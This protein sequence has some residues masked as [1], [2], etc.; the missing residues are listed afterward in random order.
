MT[1]DPV[2]RIR[3][4]LAR[5][6]PPL[7]ELL[8]RNRFDPE[9][10]LQRVA[11]WRDG[12][13]SEA[14][15]RVTGRVEPPGP[16]HIDVL[17]EPGSAAHAAAH[18]A[19]LELIRAGRVGALILNGGMAT[20]FG[21]VVKGTVEALPGRS[22]LGLKLEQLAALPGRVPAFLM[23]SF[24]TDAATGE[25]LAALRPAVPVTTFTQGIAVRITPEGGLF[26]VA[27]DPSATLYAPGHG[28]TAE[29]FRAA[30]L[31]R[32]FREAG[33]EWLVVS[34]VDNVGATVDPAVVG[35]AAGSG[36]P[37]TVELAERRAGDT[38]GMPAVLDGRP[39]ILEAFRFPE[40]FDDSP[41]RWFNTNTLALHVS[42]L[43]RDRPLTWFAVRKEVAGRTVIQFERL[44]G[45]L[46]AFE[47]TLLLGVPREGPRSRFL[48]VKTPADLAAMRDA[49]TAVADTPV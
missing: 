25:H 9:A 14:A 42:V 24:A 43:E 8:A 40:G 36:R 48:P 26:S 27:D 6:P 45:E 1:H 37:L 30:D 47:T 18:E 10:F 35:R 17:P 46:A 28:D 39:V 2:A 29:A 13:L 44:I 21:G 19:G 16:E 32:R 4:E 12:E 41:I 38:G 15:G 34:N 49:I 22:F 33:G 3:G 5:L 7:P 31:P 11:R 20:R 23:N